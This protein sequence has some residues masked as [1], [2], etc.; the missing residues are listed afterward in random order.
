MDVKTAFLYGELNEIVFMKRE[1]G[2]RKLG[3]SFEKEYLW[4]KAG[5]ALLEYCP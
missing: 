5:T 2:Q 1:R 3:V 4:F